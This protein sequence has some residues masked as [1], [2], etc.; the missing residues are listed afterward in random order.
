MTLLLIAPQSESHS[1]STFRWYEPLSETYR[2]I[3]RG[4]NE[5]TVE[6]ITLP[7][8]IDSELIYL[9]IN[10]H[11]FIIPVSEPYSTV[12]F[13]MPSSGYLDIALSDGKQFIPMTEKWSCS[14]RFSYIRTWWNIGK[15]ITTG[16]GAVFLGFRY[17]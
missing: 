5:I 11:K 14:I 3:V 10:E 8:P 13:N 15:W 16:I 1:Y 17:I 2:D 9:H 12:E 7:K 4:A 6:N